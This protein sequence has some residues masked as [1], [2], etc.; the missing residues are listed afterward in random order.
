MIDNDKIAQKIIKIF[1][2]SRVL[3][4]DWKFWIPRY[5]AQEQFPIIRV[6][7]NFADGINYNLELYERDVP[8][9]YLADAYHSTTDPRYDTIY[10]DEKSLIVE[11][12]WFK[13]K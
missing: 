6:A 5:I 2:D 10:N 1:S 12:G 11:K 7:K 9:E 8:S 3:Q 4:N 13:L